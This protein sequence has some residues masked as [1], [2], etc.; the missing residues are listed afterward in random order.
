LRGADLLICADCVPFVVADFHRRYLTGRVVL[1][2]CPKLD[3]LE[4]YREK[5]VEILEQARPASLLVLRIEVPCCSGIVA[6]VRDARDL[7]MPE[8]PL[9]VHVIGI[10]G[11]LCRQNYPGRVSEELAA[12]QQD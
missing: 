1:V 7:V 9:E 8:L 3:D 11:D 6:A 2:G 12:S 4:H 10:Q 5:L